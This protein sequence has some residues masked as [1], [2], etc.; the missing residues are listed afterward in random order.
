MAQETEAKIP[1]ADLSA[2][3]AKLLALGAEDRGE[4]FERNRVF[5]DGGGTLEERGILLR[6][7]THG[8][9]RGGILTVKRIVG[10]GAFKTREEI[11]TTTD[12]ADTLLSQLD[13]LGYRVAWIYEKR[14]RTLLWGGCVF[15][16]DTCPEIGTFVEIEGDEQGIR[17]ACAAVGLDPGSHLPGNYLALWRQHLAARGEAPRDMTFAHKGQTA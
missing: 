14:R 7:R 8:A 16:L 1:V 3:H 11:E 17:A 9:E 10:G 5:D 15:A 12:D 4:V 2:V 13:I 6:L